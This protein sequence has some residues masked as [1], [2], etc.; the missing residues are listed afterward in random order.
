MLLLLLLLLLGLAL[1]LL[2]L[3]RML[4]GGPWSR[5]DEDIAACGSVL[6]CIPAHAAIAVVGLLLL[7]L[8]RVL[9]SAVP[10]IA[11]SLIGI[12]ALSL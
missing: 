10:L 6:R 9:A 7:L 11:K 1:L 2:L 3:L 5:E 4:L 8:R 12:L